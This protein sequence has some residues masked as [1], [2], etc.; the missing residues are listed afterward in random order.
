MQDIHHSC[1]ACILAECHLS[2]PILVNNSLI[3]DQP[4]ILFQNCVQQWHVRFLR[5]YRVRKEAVGLVRD[6]RV[7]WNLFNTENDTRVTDI[8]LHASTSLYVWLKMERNIENYSIIQMFK[9]NTLNYPTKIEYTPFDSLTKIH[10]KPILSSIRSF[11]QKSMSWHTDQPVQWRSR[12]LKGASVDIYHIFIDLLRRLMRNI[13]EHCVTV[14]TSI[15]STLCAHNCIC[16]A[17]IKTRAPH[18]FPQLIISNAWL[19]LFFVRSINKSSLPLSDWTII[20][21][22]KF[23]LSPSTTYEVP[24]PYL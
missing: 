14:V 20:I 19:I 16:D 21:I 15:W 1:D 6:Q 11:I 23:C 17:M 12:S 8:F 10:S 3:I 5:F 24:Y 7:H 22:L 13:I 18:K 4:N 9:C 2:L